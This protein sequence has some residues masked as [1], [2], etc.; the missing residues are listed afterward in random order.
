MFA[1]ATRGGGVDTTKGAKFYWIYSLANRMI[2]STRAQSTELRGDD[3]FQEGWPFFLASSFI[4]SLIRLVF[5]AFIR[6]AG[7]MVEEFCKSVM[8]F[9]PHFISIS[10]VVRAAGS[11]VCCLLFACCPFYCLLCFIL[12]K[13][14]EDYSQSLFGMFYFCFLFFCIFLYFECI[15]GDLILLRLHSIYAT[16]RIFKPQLRLIPLSNRFALA[17]CC[18]IAYFCRK[19]VFFF[20]LPKAQSTRRYRAKADGGRA[21]SAYNKM[22]KYCYSFEDIRQLISLYWAYANIAFC[23]RFTSFI[24]IAGEE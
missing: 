14:R 1:P 19:I 9:H 6:P 5:G 24:F 10:S 23:F 15:C 16:V 8:D 2:S 22:K 12:F 13:V 21:G 3:G 20:K 17:P 4:T 7:Q 11:T 18:V